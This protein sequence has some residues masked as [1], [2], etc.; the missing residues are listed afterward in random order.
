MNCSI[1]LEELDV[2]KGYIV[3]TK[4][5]CKEGQFFHYGCIGRWL[6]EKSTCP[7]CN[8]NLL[9]YEENEAIIQEIIQD[10]NIAREELT[11]E[12]QPEVQEEAQPETQNND[13]CFIK[14]MIDLMILAVVTPL[15]VYAGL[16]LGEYLEENM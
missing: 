16:Y 6:L 9:D 11:P 8:E 5:R 7:M 12:I 13:L 1:C 14:L 15:G 2:E 10:C 3:N 4:C